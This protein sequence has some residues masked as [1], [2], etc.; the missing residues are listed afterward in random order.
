MA[1]VKY[2]FSIADDTLNGAVAP[3]NLDAEI[4]ADLMI[5]KELAGVTVAGEDLYVDFLAALD[6]AEEA[7][8]DAVVAAHDGVPTIRGPGQ[9]TSAGVPFTMPAWREGN[10]TDFMSHNWCDKT[11]WY[12]MS[13]RVVNEV[14]T[15]NSATEFA[16]AN[17]YWI[18]VTHG[19]ITQEYRLYDS[20]YVAVTVDDV[21]MTESSPDTT[22]GDYQVDYETGVVTFNSSQSG[23][24]VKATYSYATT[25]D[26]FVEPNPGTKLRFTAVEAQ[27]STDL[28]L[29]DTVIFDFEGYVQYYAPQLVNDVNPD[30]VT[31]FPTGTRI[32]LGYRREYKTMYD[33]IAEAQRAYP[34]IPALGGP[35][36]R[37]LQNPIQV[38]RWP[39]QEDATRDID[40]ASGMRIRIKLSSDVPY[41]GSKASVTLYSISTNSEF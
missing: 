8:L 39:Y 5:T 31:S 4:R 19:K 15:E 2:N 38:Y 33:Y 21:A 18:D 12:T 3:R 7:A 20:Y 41:G 6:M 25:S 37:G 13:S 11:T 36:W 23:K 16:S 26:F 40:S 30:Y 1:I 17:P 32:P 14:L 28:V 22:D 29:T 35:G 27:F 34:E 9:Y 10:P 24:T